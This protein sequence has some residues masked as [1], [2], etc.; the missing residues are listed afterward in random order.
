MFPPAKLPLETAIK[1]YAEYRKSPENWMLGRFICSAAQLAS[2]G[3][4]GDE[5]F[6]D[7]PPFAYSVIGRGGN[8]MPL[9]LMNLQADLDD[10]AAF[11]KRHGNRVTT[12][13]YEARLPGEVFYD[14]PSL[15][16]A[17][18]E[19][20]TLYLEEQGPPSFTP[21]YEVSGPDIRPTMNSVIRAISDFRPGRSIGGPPSRSRPAGF[22]LRCGGLE[23]SA[24][25][26]PELV[27]FVITSCRNAEVSLKFTAGLHHPIRRDDP[28]TNVTMHGFLNILCA[29]VLAAARGLEEEEIA[30]V[31]ID[32]DPSSFQFDD[33][34]FRWQDRR[35]SVTEI[36][37]ARRRGVVSFGSC[38]FDEPRDDLRALGLLR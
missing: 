20:V 8:T 35:A 12:E 28:E 16:H 2:I 17:L 25:P 31:L 5:L 27:A 30:Q 36:E 13:V 24:Y 23:P 37:A 33:D 4:L 9:F 18:F 32:E 7:G 22:K 26:P 11:R 15:T 6:R 21:F 38:S 3:S 29:G 34:G 10:I 19:S 1:N 14:D